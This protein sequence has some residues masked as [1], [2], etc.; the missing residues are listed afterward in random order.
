EP[1]NNLVCYNNIKSPDVLDGLKEAT[2]ARIGIGHSGA[3]YKT[4][5]M[6]RF[7]ADQA[8]AADA[9]YSEVS[10]ETVKKLGVFEVQTRCR[11]KYEMITRPNLGRLFS[12]ETLDI[13]KEKCIY[14]PDVQIY[15][16]DGL[17]SPSIEAN[18]PYLY[19]TIKAGL[20]S[21]GVTIGT[22][23]FVR[24]CRVN[25]ARYIG[26]LLKAK[27][28]CVLIGE[29]PGLITSE[30]MSAYIAYNARPDMLES[31]YTVVSNISKAGIPPVE[32][33]AYIVDII[34]EMLEKGC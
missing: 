25:T 5:A 15:F 29:R 27:V 10:D 21:E 26:S 14:A 20:E 18:I 3:R 17:C 22:P 19:P 6:L 34:K 28:T 23:F 24:Y 16:G 7:W 13:I 8:A 33:G 2:P 30:S 12:D 31:D 9:V 1:I 32:A 4:K 11:S